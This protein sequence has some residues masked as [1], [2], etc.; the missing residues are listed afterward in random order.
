METRMTSMETSTNHSVQ[1]RARE[2]QDR[3]APQLEQAR[4]ALS[5]WNTKVST[6]VRERPGTA[7]LGALAFG[8]LVGKIAS[9]R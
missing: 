8:Y 9:R 2:L 1:D 6:F 5:D 7:L 4:A 3:L